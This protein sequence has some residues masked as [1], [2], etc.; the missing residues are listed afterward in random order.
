M[1]PVINT[2]I[3]ARMN[4]FLPID[5]FSVALHQ[6]HPNPNQHRICGIPPNLCKD[7]SVPARLAEALMGAIFFQHFQS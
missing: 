3:D 1:V 5:L 4:I 7:S 2:L 6:P